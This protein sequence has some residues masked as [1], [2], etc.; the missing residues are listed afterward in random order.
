[1]NPLAIVILRDPSI[2]EE[3]QSALGREGFTVRT[4]HQG[5]GWSRLLEPQGARLILVGDDL[6]DADPGLLL[7]R[8]R[9]RSPRIVPA[10]IHVADGEP[11]RSHP[12]GEE[13]LEGVE[14]IAA[15]AGS[16]RE[17]PRPPVEKGVREIFNEGGAVDLLV[18]GKHPAMKRMLQTIDAV[19]PT[20]TTVLIG[21]ESGTGKD[22]VARLIH[23]RSPR[24][25][26]PWV[27]V[28][29]GAI[30]PNLMESELFGHV[31]GSFTGAAEDKVGLCVAAD[32]GTLFLDEIGELP[33]ELQV[34]LLRVLQTGIVR[35][36]GGTDRR[37]DFRVL[38]A[39][40][41]DLKRE[42]QAGRFRLD[43]YYRVNVISVELPPLRER[44]SD[45]PSLCER[46]VG[47]LASRG[48][49]AAQLAPEVLTV[50]EQ[51]SWP[52][53]IR[54]L[55]NVVERLL[56]L[57]PDGTAPEDEVRHQLQDLAL[58][59][60][61]GDG[62]EPV[63]GADAHYPIDMTLKDLQDAHID[64]VLRHFG[65]NKTLAAKALGVNVKTVYN[66]VKRKNEVKQ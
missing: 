53:N 4:A 55:E 56:L 12:P 3:L 38:A 34:K 54:E 18:P 21:G 33:L 52:G 13:L 2:R 59:A 63:V 16:K 65:G 36:V 10:L 49:P 64:R 60:A 58:P 30:P 47:R 42:V 11:P 46:I 51:H 43:L 1:M 6:A 37:V 15:W 31:K 57:H 40:N 39:T 5:E 23:Q 24:A 48:L 41:R 26:G 8:A 50:L 44:T 9:K 25:E 28:N 14:A 20:D 62:A 66:R 7:D 22:L 19:S 32:G 29:C 17:L 45:I 61:A 35:P 27:P